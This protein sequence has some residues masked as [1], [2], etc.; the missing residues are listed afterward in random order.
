MVNCRKRLVPTIAAT[1]LL[2]ASGSYWRTGSAKPK[3]QS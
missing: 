1:S 2:L 3:K